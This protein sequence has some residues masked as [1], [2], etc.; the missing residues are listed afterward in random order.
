MFPPSFSD[1]PAPAVVRSSVGTI[2]DVREKCCS[3]SFSCWVRERM[4]SPPG[5]KRLFA[6]SLDCMSASRRGVDFGGE[7]GSVTVSSG[8]SGAEREATKDLKSSSNMEGCNVSLMNDMYLKCE[9]IRTIV[10][11]SLSII[12]FRGARY[13]LVRGKFDHSLILVS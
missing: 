9:I 8:P 10:N 1:P 7:I 12:A 2:G 3:S 6:F 13:L 5:P 4:V 11:R